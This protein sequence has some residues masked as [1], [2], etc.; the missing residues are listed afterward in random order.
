MK[1]WVEW[2]F[3]LILA[4]LGGGF[5][6]L[7]KRIKAQSVEQDAVVEGVKAILHDRLYQAYRYYA[8]LGFCP[9]EDKKNIEYIYTPYHNLGGNG[10][11]TH[12]YEQLM[13]MPTEPVQSGL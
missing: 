11:G 7:K 3:G 4:G 2:G 12:I 1:Y 8:G 13:D 5:A 6:W 10:T 9:I